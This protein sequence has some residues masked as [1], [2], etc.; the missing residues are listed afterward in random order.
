MKALFYMV[1]ILAVALVAKPSL[2]VEFR[3]QNG[4]LA[5]QA[6]KIACRLNSTCAVANGIATVGG[7]GPQKAASTTALTKEDCGKVI[8]N[9]AGATVQPLPALT[10][11]TVGCRLTFIVVDSSAFNI[12]PDDSDIIQILTNSAGDSIASSTVGNSVV[13]E[14]ISVSIWAPVGKEQG[15][16]TD[17]N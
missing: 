15:T 17:S 7:A 10:A 9:S 12:N 3:T 11:S 2:A 16:W 6:N 8:V 1:M 4:A 5:G 14:G 13:L